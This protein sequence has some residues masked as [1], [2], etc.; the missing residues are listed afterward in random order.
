MRKLLCELE[1][2]LDAPTITRC[3]ALEAPGIL[4][5]QRRVAVSSR[6]DDTEKA[7]LG[8]VEQAGD[9]KPPN[10][11][12]LPVVRPPVCYPQSS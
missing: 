8:F 2:V 5:G 7:R 3:C 9:G 1:C 10:E 11:A 6:C 12:G 4:F